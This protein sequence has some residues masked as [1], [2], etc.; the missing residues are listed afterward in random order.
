MGPPR[1]EME[2]REA[3]EQRRL[4]V[5]KCNSVKERKGLLGSLL[6]GGSECNSLKSDTRGRVWNREGRD[7][8]MKR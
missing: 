4:F 1:H 6:E 7:D 3:P 2:N 8:T 5:S